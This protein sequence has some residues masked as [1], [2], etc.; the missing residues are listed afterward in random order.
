MLT[1]LAV[2]LP[3]ELE[4]LERQDGPVLT[5]P[6]EALPVSPNAICRSFIASVDRSTTT[7]A[8]LVA[9]LPSSPS[10]SYYSDF[11]V[12]MYA[13]FAASNL[14]VTVSVAECQ[15]EWCAER[16]EFILKLFRSLMTVEEVY[17]LSFVQ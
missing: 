5:E 9:A 11:I 10:R 8:L 12:S 14:D 15:D 16:A 7:L 17:F 3:V 4:K 6:M 2:L 1:D 13:S